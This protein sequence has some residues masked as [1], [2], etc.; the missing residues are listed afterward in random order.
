MILK[1]MSTGAKS[2]LL[3][4]E[5]GEAFRYLSAT[6]SLLKYKGIQA[7]TPYRLTFE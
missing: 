5:T 1:D 4:S 2:Y 7:L 6:N 3:K